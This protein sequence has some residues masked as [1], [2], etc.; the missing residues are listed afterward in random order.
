[1]NYLSFKEFVEKYG[2]KIEA[3][4]NIKS[5]KNLTLMNITECGIYMRDYKFT[6]MAGIVNLHQTKGTHWVMF[7]NEYYFNSHGCPSP[8]NIMSFIT[9][10]F[11]QNIK[12]RKMIVFVQRIVYMFCISQV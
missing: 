4:S 1:M 5:F 9:M 3:T 7:I 2:L 10:V 11:I 12:F 6:T 8:L